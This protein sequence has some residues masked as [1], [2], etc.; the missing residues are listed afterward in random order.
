MPLV[1]TTMTAPRTVFENRIRRRRVAVLGLGRSGIAASEMLL[2]HGAQVL[3]SDAGTNADLETAAARLRDL[4]AWV[5]LGSHTA[6]ALLSVDY[7]VVSPGLSGRLP[8][9]EAARRK[10]VP[11]FSEIEVA[12]WLCSGD[13][14]A[15]TGTNGKTTTV[16]LLHAI[17]ERAGLAARLAGNVGTPFA[18]I[19]DNL[20]TN[21]VVLEVSSYQ[22]EHIETFRP[23]VAALLN[24]TPD[25]LERHGSLEMYAAMKYRLGENA[26]AGDTIVL[27]ADDPLVRQMPV[28]A[29]ARALYFST[30]QFL[31]E[32]VYAEGGHLVYRMGDR[33]GRLVALEEI[34]IP[35]PHNRANA[36]AASAAALS[37]GVEPEAIAAVL[38]EFPGVPHRI[39][40]LGVRRGARVFN[41][42]KA[43]NVDAM[44]MALRSVEGPI[45]LLVGGRAKGDD[46][47]AADELI[48]AHVRQVIAFG[49]ARMRFA[50]AWRGIVPVEVVDDLA[51]ATRSA[52]AKAEPGDAILLSP[53]CAS[54]DQFKN[55]EDR[56]D[57]FRGYV[58]AIDA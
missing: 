25:H 46:P 23:R 22:L 56:G 37:Y 57:R 26:A 15:V 49:E 24:I 50:D 8:V 31:P 11:I 3:A 13:V 52:F 58:S 54:F 34:R 45:I 51:Q 35:G 27:N 20:G 1:K 10:G 6:E 41:D 40:P 38:K 4:G 43:T 48:R 2:A 18:S 12:F 30:L 42:S 5:E 55:F 39:E 47:H 32:G 28:P 19:V 44:L 29:G 33:Q 7:I 16:T 53:A 21:P 17:L 9:L 14:L 36:A